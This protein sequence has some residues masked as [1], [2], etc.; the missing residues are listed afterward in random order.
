MT[1]YWHIIPRPTI[2]RSS[3]QIGSQSVKP[4]HS[5]AALDN[6]TV[7]FSADDQPGLRLSGSHPLHVKDGAAVAHFT[8][9]HEEGA[10]FVLGGQ[11][12]RQG[13]HSF[14]Q[15]GHRQCG[16]EHGAH[17]HD[18]RNGVRICRPFAWCA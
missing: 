7:C 6:G 2:T 10:E 11:R 5:T 13:A 18:R 9:T 4:W 17:N 3:S 16:S 8:L 15:W 12:D 14:T 1:M